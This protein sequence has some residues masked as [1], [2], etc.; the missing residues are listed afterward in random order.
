MFA[1]RNRLL[2]HWLV[3]ATVV[4]LA[5]TITMPALS[6]V[7][8]AGLRS[9]R[10]SLNLQNVTLGSVLKVMTQKSGINFLI[11]SNLVG[12]E[13]NVYLEDVLVE[14]A[15]AAIL[16]ANGLW[17]TRQKGTNIYVIMESPDGPPVA[18][19][20]EVF[21]T[22]YA[23]AVELGETLTEVLTDIGSIV[24]DSRTNSL[25][26]SD[27]PENMATLRSL[28][29]ELDSPTG[30]VL[31]EAKIVEFSDDSSHELG[32]SWGAMNPLYHEDDSTLGSY[33][34]TFNNDP[35]NE[36]LFELTF[37]KF[38]SFSDIKDLTAAIS[39]LQKDG[40]ADVLAQPHILTLDNREATIEIVRNMA[41]AKKVTYREGGTESTVE[42]I[43]G[44]VGVSLKVT[45]HIN[46]ENF[47]TM[48]IEPMVSSAQRSS[49]FPDD[50]VDTKH[51]TANTT[52]MVKDGQTVVI[53]GL[54][55]KDIIETDF[56]VPILGDIP[57]L[58]KL[59]RKSITTEAE[60]EVVLFLTPRILSG[61]ALA[62]YSDRR[63]SEV[64]QRWENK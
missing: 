61:E 5:F 1:I 17:Y 34:S 56:K 41:L 13:I 31:I 19:T 3:G 44:Q 11:G 43:F 4:V 45:P 12:R 46:N 33:T 47:V 52:V 23:D 49:Y 63:E 2:R 30:Q 40:R 42:P 39:A 24:V 21:G 27:I 55:R 60:T 38:A 58:G 35:N 26:V 29:I 51:R 25:V 37:G 57:L 54:L 62:R 36:G 32:I 48:E 10:I 64:D 8:D 6:Q 53:G 9:Q 14:D 7:S 16:R 22:N 50:A 20:T 18:T 59:F 15:L 28:V